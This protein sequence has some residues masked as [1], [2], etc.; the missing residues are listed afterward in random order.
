MKLD[1]KLWLTADKEAVVE[2]GDPSAAF[3]LGGEGDEID[4]AEGER[5]GLTSRRKS[6]ATKQAD[7]PAN[8]EA[9]AP[10]N[11]ARSSGKSRK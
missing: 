7:V 5:L 10:A 11:K 8:K 2:D 6:A 4:D 3:L 9:A 1:R